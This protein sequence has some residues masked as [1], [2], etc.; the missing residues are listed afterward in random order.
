MIASRLAI[1]ERQNLETL[2]RDEKTTIRSLA[3]VSER[4]S[5]LETKKVALSEDLNLWTGRRAEVRLR[6]IL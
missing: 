6:I 2:S 5:A 1:E 3:Q 4:C